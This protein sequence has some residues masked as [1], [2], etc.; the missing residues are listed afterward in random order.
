M[1]ALNLYCQRFSSEAILTNYYL[2]MKNVW[3]IF[4]CCLHD[5]GLRVSFYYTINIRWSN[6]PMGI[7]LT[8]HG[9]SINN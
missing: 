1:D 6:K 4:T 9:K 2:L 3:Y 5:N 8:Y 7:A